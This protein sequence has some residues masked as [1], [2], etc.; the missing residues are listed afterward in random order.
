M[1]K[2]KVSLIIVVLIITSLVALTGC[3]KND[4]NT[5]NNSNNSKNEGIDLKLDFQHVNQKV[6]NARINLTENDKRTELEEEPKFAR[7]ENEKNNYVLD[8]TLDSEAKEAYGEF[9][10]S[11]KECEEYKEVNFGKYKGYYAKDGEDIFGYIL[12]DE[13]D[14][15]FNIFIN[16]VVYAYDDS[17]ENSNVEGIYNSS[18]IQNILNN[19][20]FKVSK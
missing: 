12:L 15:T 4:N 8:I 6:Y 3:T 5:G 11:A 20:E 17:S 19:I 2:L 14:D 7:I 10:A 18:N 9:Q 13:S 16:F 1:K